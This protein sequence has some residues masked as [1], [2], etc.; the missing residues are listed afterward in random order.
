M[1]EDFKK[2]RMRQAIDQM[3]QLNDDNSRRSE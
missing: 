1:I 3:S 2:Q